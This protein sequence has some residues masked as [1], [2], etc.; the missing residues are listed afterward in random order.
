MIMRSRVILPKYLKNQTKRI[1]RNRRALKIMWFIGSSNKDIYDDD[2]DQRERIM[3]PHNPFDQ[4]GDTLSAK[5][6]VVV[7]STINTNEN[8]V[9]DDQD[10]DQSPIN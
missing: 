1:L 8:L 9:Q 5:D 3:S 4:M 10:E 7:L 6:K 2:Q